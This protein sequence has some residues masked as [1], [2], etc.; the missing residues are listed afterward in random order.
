MK[1]RE[2]VQLIAEDLDD[3]LEMLKR[4]KFTYVAEEI[5][6]MLEGLGV[7]YVWEREDV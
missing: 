6:D 2:M 1:R 3:K 7:T 5:L 4:G